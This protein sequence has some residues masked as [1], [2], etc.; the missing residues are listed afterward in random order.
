MSVKEVTE[1]LQTHQLKVQAK[2]IVE[3][4]TLDQLTE[5]NKQ[6]EVHYPYSASASG[7]SS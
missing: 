2:V 6:I 3:S 1:S 7:T 4:L 5:L